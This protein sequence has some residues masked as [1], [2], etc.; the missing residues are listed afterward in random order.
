MQNLKYGTNEPIYR[1]E[2]DTQT[3]RIDLLPRGRGRVWHGPG[4]W[5]QQMQTITFRMDEQRGP[6]QHRELYPIT[7]ERI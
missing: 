4:V 5:G 7:C 3:W 1:T 2:T 6:V